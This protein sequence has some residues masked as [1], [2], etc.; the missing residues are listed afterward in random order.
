MPHEKLKRCVSD[1]LD[2]SLGLSVFPAKWAKQWASAQTPEIQRNDWLAGL[3]VGVTYELVFVVLPLLVDRLQFGN[4]SALS[5]PMLSLQIYGGLWS[6]WATTSS[7]ITST[8]ILKIIEVE[9]IPE[10]SNSSSEIIIYSLNQRFKRTNILIVS[11][12]IS[13]ICAILAG[14]IVYSEAPQATKPSTLSVIWW[15]IG[16]S[17]LFATSANVVNVS[18]F[19]GAFSEALQYNLER[20]YPLNPARSSLV[21]SISA[22]GKKMII[23]WFGIAISIALILPFGIVNLNVSLSKIFDIIYITNNVQNITLSDFVLIEVP[24]AGFFSIGLGSI[25][26]LS[27]EASIRSAVETYKRLAL[28]KIENNTRLME[29]LESI[30]KSDIDKLKEINLLH[31]AI[32]G[33]GSY[34]N[35]FSSALGIISPLVPIISLFFHDSK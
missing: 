21:L 28:R 14:Y 25:V 11:W 24:I 32:A 20:L 33:S 31:D 2:G 7:R 5:G 4:I 10:L 1:L 3:S 13:S 15:S 23:F 22:I 16:W 9:V 29:S 34:G 26:F 19:Y 8:S 27:S 18:R 30:E 6:F 35:I 12:L 17:I